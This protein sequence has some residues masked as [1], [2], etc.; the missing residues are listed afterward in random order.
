MKPQAVILL[1]GQGT[2]LRALYPDRPKALVLVAGRPFIEWQIAWLRRGGIGAIHCAAGHLAAQIEAWAQ[3]QAD[4]TVS[5]EPEPLGTGGALKF[6]GPYIQSDPFYV[7]NGDTLLPGLD[8]QRLEKQHQ[9]CSKAWKISIAVSRVAAAGRY[10]TVEFDAAGRITAFLEKAER[11]AGWINGGIYLLDGLALS[12]L[13]AARCCSLE[14]ECFPSLVADGRLVAC[15][16]DPP[17]LDMGT[18]EGLAE[19]EHH[20]QRYLPDLTQPDK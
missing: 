18:P 14:T 12:A 8:F 13:P 20:L 4:V 9:T 6:V 11:A 5:R 15:P 7:V 19:M 17:T 3:E 2:R 1:G 16:A 10:G